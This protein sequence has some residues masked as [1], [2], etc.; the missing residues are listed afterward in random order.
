[1]KSESDT[2]IFLL[3]TLIGRL[4]GDINDRNGKKDERR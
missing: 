3:I 4:K 2:N 1:M